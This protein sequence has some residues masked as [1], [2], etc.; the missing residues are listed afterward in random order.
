MKRQV[1]FR[2]FCVL[3]CALS[4]SCALWINSRAETVLRT[5]PYITLSPDKNAFTT[6]ADDRDT[7]WYT[8]GYTVS[9]QSELNLRETKPGEHYYNVVRK[10]EVSVGKWV[11][12]HVPARCVHNIV[13]KINHY[14]GV[15]F[16]KD[17]CEVPYY[18]GWVAYCADCGQRVVD[19]YFYMSDETAGHLTSLDM[20]MAYY[21]RCPHC[22]HLEQGVELR[23]HVCKDISANQYI[24][25]YHANF[26]KGYMP[27]SH[28]MYNNASM[29]EGKEVIPQKNLNLNSYTRKG[30]EFAGWNTK[31]DGSGVHYADGA[32]ILNL[33]SQEQGSVI[34]YAQWKKSQSVLEIDPSGGSYQGKKTISRIVGEYESAYALCMEDIVPPG[35]AKV[36]FETNGGEAVESIRTS[37]EF[38]EWSFRQPLQGAI[39]DNMYY[40]NGKNDSVDRVQA[41][42]RQQEFILPECE[43]EGYSFGG[44]YYDENLSR[45]AGMSGEHI[46]TEKDITL[47]ACWVDLKLQSQ[48]NYTVNG[49]KGAVNLSWTQKDDQYKQYLLYQKQAGEEWRKI[50]SAEDISSSRQIRQEFGYSGKEGCYIIPFNGYYK[51]TLFGAQGE[52]YEEYFGG[53]GGSVSAIF[54][55]EKG[56]ELSY[57]VGGQNGDGSDISSTYGSGGQGSAFGNGGAGS[58]A[59]TDKGIVLIAGGGG[60]ASAVCDGMPGGTQ[61]SV[62]AQGQG[63]S[64]MA[65]GGGGF[66]GGTAGKVITHTHG[67]SCEHEH[68]GSPEQYG[69][70][71]TKSIVCGGNDFDQSIYREVFYYGNISDE[72]EFV[73]CVRCGSYSCPGHLN[74]YFKYQCRACKSVYYDYRPQKCT[75]SKYDLACDRSAGYVCGYE[76]GEVI[77][78]VPAYGGSNYINT[79]FCINYESFDDV[80][81]GD[82]ALQIDAVCIG[83]LA[84]NHLNGVKAQDMEAPD[85][86]D[87][88]SITLKSVDIDK[89]NV[90]FN[91]PIDWGSEYFHMV[92]S[93]DPVSGQKI[94]TSNITSNTLTSGVSGYYYKV[95]EKEE[96][97]VTKEETFCRDNGAQ[98]YISVN[99]KE[100]VQY[101]HIAA[102]DKAGNLAETVHLPISKQS[103]VYWPI[104]TEQMEMLSGEA[105]CE[106]NGIYYVRADGTSSFGIHYG[107]RLCGSARENYQINRMVMEVQNETNTQEGALTLI[108]PMEENIVPGLVS[109]REEK[110]HKYYVNDPGIT[111]ASYT[112][113]RRSD[114][115]KNITAQ[116]FFSVPRE[117]D[118]CSFRLTPR[119]GIV[120]GRLE[121]FSRKESDQENGLTVIADGQGPI[122]SGMDELQKVLK[123]GTT[124]WEYSL[125]LYAEDMG[126]GVSEFELEISNLDNGGYVQ[127]M[128][129][130]QDGWIEVD[131][132]SDNALFSG[133]FQLLATAV[134]RVGNTSSETYGFDGMDVSA[135]IEEIREP[136]D[137][138]FQKGE[139]A[140][141][142]IQAVGYIEKVQVIFP[143]EW[144]RFGENQNKEYYYVIPEMIQTEELA[145]KI[146]LQCAEGTYKI[147][148]RA[149]K[150]D[151]ILEEEPELTTIIV[152]GSI[153]DE[154]RTRLR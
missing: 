121:V 110:I 84:D 47:Y 140:K 98:P 41:V 57:F 27:G 71:Y 94:S 125:R 29:Y 109:Y 103:V 147:L 123:K 6:N 18:S 88:P 122:I 145:F 9:I 20:S 119:A 38:V 104:I 3:I 128:D 86:I 152:S 141:L 24:V 76:D 46:K 69:G 136:L 154:I 58:Y 95:D 64:G 50:Y 153:L 78:A 52:N 23:Q 146:P 25:R 37:M 68:I 34:L 132:D 112:E 59:A 82:G 97:S 5:N 15:E 93:V 96:T 137:G 7:E 2:F 75:G 120:D 143:E 39:Q 10:G 117:L 118:G 36:S 19:H 45:M 138:S 43:K 72:G 32:E 74:E 12:E 130:D 144:N 116:Q 22:T 66:R 1:W 92:E 4:L 149:Y 44:W 11:V 80:K 150:G 26:G 21:Y 63:E 17:I 83:F 33:S 115:C 30:Y 139:T 89:V 49:G 124:Q 73:F 61:V 35:G 79:E 106:S 8:R 102:V 134:D 111:E 40:F 55:L 135:Y 113:L 31:M 129:E 28:H 51:I 54:Y 90:V 133:K 114:Y 77:Q 60:G 91:R 65:G 13:L 85:K 42:Y 107:A 101:I 151:K 62:V 131:M 53:K 56:E 67:K 127:I 142:H 100:N 108:F 105:V 16:R 126:S 14:H 87:A 81:K 70:C 148:V 99:L 48:N